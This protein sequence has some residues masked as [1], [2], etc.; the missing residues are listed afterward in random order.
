MMYAGVSG[1]VKVYSDRL[2]AGREAGEDLSDL[3]GVYTKCRIKYPEMELMEDDTH[4]YTDPE[5][6]WGPYKVYF[7]LGDYFFEGAVPAALSGFNVEVTLSPEIDA[8]VPLFFEIPVTG[9]GLDGEEKTVVFT[10]SCPGE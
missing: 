7:S 6:L 5:G 4:G 10:G 9:R 8:S 3:A 1:P 2:V